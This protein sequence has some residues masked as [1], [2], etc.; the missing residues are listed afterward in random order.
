[1][2]KKCKFVKKDILTEMSSKSL[3]ESFKKAIDRFLSKYHRSKIHSI[4]RA[5]PNYL[6]RYL[7]KNE[8]KKLRKEKYENFLFDHFT[9][10]LN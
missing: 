10:I 9:K 4:C 7:G 5:L 3:S 1:M 6:G 2:C 8:A